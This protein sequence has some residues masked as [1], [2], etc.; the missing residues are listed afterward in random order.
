[1]LDDFLV[2]AALA[3][4]GVAAAAGLLGCFVVWRRMAYFGDAT[5]H[6]AVLGVAIALGFSVSIFVGVFGVALLMALTLWALTSRTL[7]QDAILGVLAYG[8]IA[9][10]LVASSLMGGRQ[11]DLNAYLF[12]DVLTVTRMDLAVVWS[13]AVVIAVVL[14]WRWQ[15]LL[16]ST[17]SPDLARAAGIDPRREELVLT[18]LLATV[19]AVSIKVVGALLITALLIIPAAAA[20]PLARTP[21]S[22]ACWAVALG[23]GAALLGLWGALIFNTPVGATM[24]CASVLLFA[25][26]RSLGGMLRSA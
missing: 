5:A 17:L 9:V 26:T 1:M 13:G 11:V 4:V 7:G 24:V 15:A 19:V 22:M 23:A 10:G 14:A 18:L 20:R 21:E 8:A 12:A 2:R 3:A 16:T 6:A 25:I